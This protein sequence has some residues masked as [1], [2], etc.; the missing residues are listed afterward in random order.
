MRCLGH[1]AAVLKQ[2]KF[3]IGGTST[4]TTTMSSIICGV[5]SLTAPSPRHR[6]HQARQHGGP[7]GGDH[8]GRVPPSALPPVCVQQQQGHAA[9][10]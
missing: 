4:T 10:L 7:D 8:G 5:Q 9:P 1:C 3:R 2:D 6:G